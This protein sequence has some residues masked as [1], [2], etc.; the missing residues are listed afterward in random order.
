VLRRRQQELIH[1]SED[2]QEGELPVMAMGESPLRLM[3][4]WK[5]LLLSVMICQVAQWLRI[6]L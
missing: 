3:D 6:S 5:R 1:A 2:P 4:D